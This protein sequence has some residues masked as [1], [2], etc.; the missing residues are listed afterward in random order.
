MGKTSTAGYGVKALWLGALAGSAIVS[1]PA[2]AQQRSYDIAPTSLSRALR[3]FGR[4]SGKQI[5]YSEEIV[6]EKRSPQIKGSYSPEEVLQ[7]LLSGS[8]LSSQI[9]PAGAIMVT[10]APAASASLEYPST[11]ES[12][13]QA[14]SDSLQASEQSETADIVVTAQK[15][16]EN[17]QDVPSSVSVV[18]TRFLDDLH[19]TNLADIGA[20]VPGLQVVSTGTPGQT[21]VAIRGVVPIAG[22]ATVATYIDDTPVGGNSGYSRTANFALDL[23]PYDVQRI[24]VLRGPQGTLYGASALTGLIKYVL[25]TPDLDRLHVRVGGD[26]LG[27]S[28]ASN[29]GG[30]GRAQISAP[31]VTG[32]LAALA[33]YS[34]EKTPGY[35]DNSQ[36]GKRNQNGVQ[37][38]SARLGLRWVP[39]DNLSIN[40]GALYQSIDADGAGTL[41]LSSATFKPLVGDLKD[42]NYVPQTFKKQIQFYSGTVNL[43]L[44]WATLTSASSYSNSSVDQVQDFTRTY[45][46]L[47][48]L[49]GAPAAITPFDLKLRLHKFTQE[50]RLASPSSGAFQW[51]V[52][53]FYTHEKSTNVQTVPAFAFPGSP[54]LPAVFNPLA[55]LSIPSKYQEYAFFGNL[56]YRFNDMLAITGGVRYS[57]NDQTF[58]Q[59]GSGPLIGP[60]DAP[61]SSSENVVTY[62]VSPEVHLASDVLLYGRVAS[63]YRPGGPNF[64]APGL[65]LSYKS[66]RVTNYEIG[67]KSQFL[68]KRALFDVAAFY[69]DWKDIQI[70]ILSP[71]GISGFGN[72]G[73]A[74]NVGVE[75]NA[76]LQATNALQIGGTFTFIDAK[77]REDIPTI[78]GLADARLPYTPRFSGSVQADYR[79]DLGPDLVGHLGGGLRVQGKRLSDVSSSPTAFNLPAY[80]A[81]DLNADIT[82]GAVTVRLFAKNVTDRRAYLNYN[83]IFNGATGAIDQVKGAIIQPRTIGIAADFKL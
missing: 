47:L 12:P 8:G 20:Y 59:I 7:R 52:G 29:P 30:G 80:V 55:V 11:S 17:V 81:L 31:L 82:R 76:S 2:F 72:G 60:S 67:F 50:V 10:R 26:L 43:D 4:I 35:I 62:S 36:T 13:V 22:G 27:V 68:D 1:A 61:G 49:F 65:P 6:R 19:A 25:T 34:Y 41:A 64:V 40:L 39:T 15:R 23:L 63:G 5:I 16:V 45:G 33:S 70:P 73:K 32:K 56:T 74:R 37:Q 28:G 58:R 14:R 24:E 78:N 44:N 75:A 54:A 71:S 69:I 3:D 9:T 21:A 53:G 79:A 18:G 46:V 66:D 83:P 57:E 38:Q 51:L 42:N 77:L 48:P